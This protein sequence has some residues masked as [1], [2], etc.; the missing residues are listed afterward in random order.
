MPY[1]G[2]TEMPD[3]VARAKYYHRKLNVAKLVQ[4]G[5]VDTLRLTSLLILA[6]APTTI[7]VLDTSKIFLFIF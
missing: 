5:F 4:C 2:A 7:G 3:V 6:L 1:E